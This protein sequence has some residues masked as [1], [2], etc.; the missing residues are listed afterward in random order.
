M[1]YLQTVVELDSFLKQAKAIISDEERMGV[2]T[3]LS[4]NPEVSI[5]L[6]GTCEVSATGPLPSL[7]AKRGN[8][9]YLPHPLDCFASLAMTTECMQRGAGGFG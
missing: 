4:A 6:G 7:R 1:T 9:D 2:V 8:P 5:S 3:F